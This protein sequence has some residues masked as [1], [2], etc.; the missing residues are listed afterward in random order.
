MGLDESASTYAPPEGGDSFEFENPK[1][2]DVA[3]DGNIMTKTGSMVGYTG[4]I[5]FE[6]KSIGDLKGMLRQKA[7]GKGDA[8]MQATGADHPHPTDQGEEVQILEL[9]VGEGLSVNGSDVPASKSSM[10]WDIKML[11]NVAGISSGGLFNVLLEGPGHVA[12]T[13][14]DKSITVSTPVKTDPNTTV[15]WSG[16]ASPSLDRDI[17]IKELFDRSSDESYQ[18]G[19]AGED[20]FAIVQLLKEVAPG[21]WRSG[22]SFRFF[23]VARRSRSPREPTRRGPKRR[24]SLVPDEDIS[25]T[26]MVMSA[27][28]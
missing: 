23:T 19:F 8:M 16:N 25:T 28:S 6:R 9:D 21:R 4:D 27:P 20:G 7:I 22:R 26:R 18:F 12:I 1:S 3:L 11:T 17:D 2:L 10:S 14:H 24:V 15:V 13:T 5:S